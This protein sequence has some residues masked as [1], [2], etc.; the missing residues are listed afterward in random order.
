MKILLHRAVSF[1][2]FKKIVLLTIALAAFSLKAQVVSNLVVAP[3]GPEQAPIIYVHG[4]LDDGA[5]IARDKTFLLEDLIEPISVKYLR[6]YVIGPQFSPSACFTEAGIENYAVQWWG[7]DTNQLRV[8]PFTRATNGYAFLQNAEELLRGTDWVRGTWT[9]QYKPIPS[10]LDVLTAS[11]MEFNLIPGVNYLKIIP[12]GKELGFLALKSA[13]AS[14]L[15]LVNTYNDAGRVDDH[16]QNLL[17]MLRRERQPGGKFANYQQINIVTHSKGSLDTRA[18]LHKASVASRVD[19]EYVANVVYNAPPFAGSSLPQLIKIFYEPTTLTPAI[20]ND[21]WLLKSLGVHPNVGT[22]VRHVFDRLVRPFGVTFDSIYESLPAEQRVPIDVLNSITVPTDFNWQ[23]LSTN[24]MGPPT[25]LALNIIRPIIGGLMGWPGIPSHD[26]L[27]PAGGVNHITGYNNSPDAKQFITYGTG[28]FDLGLFP[29]NLSQVATNP[30]ILADVTKNFQSEDDVAVPEGSAK[31]LTVTT[32]FGPVMTLLYTNTGYT[33][34]DL[35]YDEAEVMVAVWLGAFLAPQSSLTLTGSVQVAEAANRSYVVSSNSSFRFTAVPVTRRGITVNASS[36]EYR[37]QKVGFG[38]FAWTNAAVGQTLSF[39]SL[40]STFGLTNV[41]FRLQWR[42]INA[43]GGREMV[44]TAT[45]I[46]GGDAPQIVSANII[47]PNPDHVYKRQPH[48]LGTSGL[49][50]TF[51]TSRPLLPGLSQIV[52][53]PEA[54]FVVRQ[55]Q[56][57]ALAVIF[58]SR[59][60]MEY[61]WDNPSFTATTKLTN[62]NFILIGLTNLSDGAHTLYFETSK[63]FSGITK[64]SPRQSVVIVADNTKPEIAFQY[65]SDHSLSYVVGPQTPLRFT[66]EDIGSDG[67]TGTATVP[68]YTNGLIPHN[69]T[70]FLGDTNLREVGQSNGMS[71][72]FVT[73]GLTGTDVVGNTTSTNI[74]LF[75]DW[76]PPTV[77]V[78]DVVGGT[79]LS[80][81]TWR[82]FTNTTSVAL[83]ITDTASGF[84]PPSVTVTPLLD[85]NLAQ[86][87][88]FT[89]GFLPAWPSDYAGRVKLGPGTN[90]LYATTTDVVGNMVSLPFYIDFLAEPFDTVPLDQLTYRRDDVTN[91]YTATG[92][93]A[94]CLEGD[95]GNV[96]FSFYGDEFLFDSTGT[97]FAAGDNNQQRDVFGWTNGL[98]FRVSETTNSE[99]ARGGQ[100]D[101]PAISGNGRYAFFRSAA[102][103]LVEGANTQNLFVKDLQSGRLAVVSLNTNGL[104]INSLN[105]QNYRQTAVTYS[106]R[107]VFFQSN[108]ALDASVTD[109]NNALDIFVADLDPDSDGDFIETNYVI[110]CLSKTAANAAGNRQSREPDLSADGQFLV[111]ITQAT[112]LHSALVVNTNINPAN[113]VLLF[114]F[115][116]SESNNTL[117][118]TNPIIVPIDT[119]TNTGGRLLTN[120]VTKARVSPMN[121]SVVFEANDNVSGTGDT[122]N[123]SLGRDVYVSRRNGASVINRT[124]SWFSQGR[125]GVTQSSTNAGAA[126]FN[127]LSVGWDQTASGTTNNKIGWASLHTN[128]VPAV[129]DNNN[130]QDLFIKR[131]VTNIS[132]FP[133]TNLYIINWV[134]NNQPSAAHVTDGGVTP[135]G[136]FGWW[137]TTQTYTAPYTNGSIANLFIRRLD[138]PL[139]NTLTLAVSGQGSI[140]RTPSGVTNS[141]TTFQYVD[142]DSVLLV[143]VPSNGWRFVSWT[144]ESNLFGTNLQVNMRASHS[145]TANFVAAS[146][147]GTG[148]TNLTTLEDTESNGLRPSITDIDPDDQH[149]VHLLSLPTNGVASVENNLIYYTPNSNYHGADSITFYLEDSYGLTS[150]VRT[151]SVTVTPVNDAPQTSGATIFT[152]ANQTSPQ[153]LPLFSDPDFGDTVSLSIAVQAEFGNATIISNRLIYTPPTNFYGFDSFTYQVTDSGGLSAIG[154]ANVTI[155]LGPVPSLNIGFDTNF[156]DRPTLSWTGFVSGFQ[157]QATRTLQTIAWSNSVETPMQSGN[158]VIV[159]LTS[160]NAEGYFR[161]RKP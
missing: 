119:V 69:K 53:V 24:Y 35:I 33:H 100:S 10:A 28:G 113:H 150:T 105:T 132:E 85:G 56:S 122:N 80:S 44:R 123:V 74:Q 155:D 133:N 95:L 14:Q 104:P 92:S 101:L 41:P 136:R 110:R 19:S 125:P 61:V 103:N 126:N 63:T 158:K 154:I 118:V 79:Q 116:G 99:P 138:P 135:D 11:D 4:F 60:E 148:N 34:D 145:L 37:V 36:F 23:E 141:P 161:L 40:R 6:Y 20:F 144:G 66:V 26:D 81:N 153:T 47:T 48:L 2:S 84:T 83:R 139:T 29:T 62:A 124:I 89:L 131:T 42:A 137:V 30:S 157:L 159:P 54:S 57:K 146:A 97:R 9:A 22:M 111:F 73:I 88:P 94:S 108:R 45:I 121:D 51:F 147:P 114:A 112:N 86:T 43:K 13:I 151:V 27:T 49:R 134:A 32:N 120:G 152:L 64:K 77:S 87:D 93:V 3:D 16:G 70:F 102:S 59:G 160:T 127:A 130:L 156:P 58:D 5:P 1:A 67:G 39:L 25:V 107:Y 46:I 98:V 82:V 65:K 71:S 18:M 21:P 7:Y 129:S 128:M 68:G 143:P 76:T 50:S 55:Q 38:P 142:T 140:Q 17:D 8:S 75:Y 149:T 90:L 15:M 115:S 72:G 117:S 31:L 78:L 12:F 96:A 91:C 109:T 106:G 52:S